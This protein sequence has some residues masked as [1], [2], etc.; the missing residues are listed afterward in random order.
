MRITMK[1]VA[2]RAEV[3]IKTVS[4]VVNGEGEIS[5]ETIRRVQE[6]IDELGYRPNRMA[7]GL[8]TQRT[9]SIGLV[10]PNIN[11][12]FYPEVAEAIMSTARARQHRRDESD[13][14]GEPGR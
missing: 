4:R 12:P 14:V 2:Q 8:V 9:N 5:E 1:D 3:S 10:V 11:N 13:D 6:V 7:R